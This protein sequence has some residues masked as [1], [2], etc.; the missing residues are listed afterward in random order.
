M[1]KRQ[2][3]SRTDQRGFT[4]IEL[5]IVVVVVAI[6]AAVAFPSFMGSIRKGRR[7]E[8]FT[9]LAAVQQAQERWRGGHSSY[10]T[11]LA[12]L[13]VNSPTPSGYYALTLAAPNTPATVNNGY[14]AIAEAQSGTTQAGDTQCSKI[15]VQLSGGNVSYC[16]GGNC[17]S[18]TFANTDPCWSR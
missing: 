11:T 17:T 5:M 6:L 14:I 8:A 7:S 4:L 16:S 3:R 9:A 12:D 1:S 13:S 18:S 2:L 15:G 10:T